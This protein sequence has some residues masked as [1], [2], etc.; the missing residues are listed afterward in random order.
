MKIAKWIQRLLSFFDYSGMKFG[1]VDR[2][3]LEYWNEV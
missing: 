3:I 1:K 2:E